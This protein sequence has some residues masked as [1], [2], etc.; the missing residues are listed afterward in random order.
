MATKKAAK[1]AAD[2]QTGETGT[3][4]GVRPLNE[5]EI[6]EVR[7]TGRLD[8]TERAQAL[9]KG[10]HPSR[11]HESNLVE[12]EEM[13]FTRIVDGKHYGPFNADAPA[14]RRRVPRSL[15]DTFNLKPSEKAAQI[16]TGTGGKRPAGIEK[17]VSD[18]LNEV[19]TEEDKLEAAEEAGRDQDTQLENRQIAIDQR[20]QAFIESGAIEGSEAERKRLAGKK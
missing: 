4:T 3:P 2:R 9:P 7:K 8:R 19:P 12:V 15:V 5:D 17:P 10:Q 1:S 14:E 11:T 13:R 18:P 6:D 20:R 16:E